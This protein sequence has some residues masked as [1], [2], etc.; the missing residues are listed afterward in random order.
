MGYEI[1]FRLEEFKELA[2]KI[3]KSLPK[4]LAWLCKAFLYGLETRWI[5]AKAKAAVEASISNYWDEV[6]PK[7]TLT[8]PTYHEEESE[9]E[10]LPI[11]SLTASYERTGTGEEA[12]G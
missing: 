6:G 5:D 7:T 8:P 1:K 2:R 12:K 11:M 10:G 4:A 9:V 3:D